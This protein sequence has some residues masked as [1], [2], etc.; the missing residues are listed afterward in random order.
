MASLYLNQ[1]TTK[2]K[3]IIAF[4]AMS[5]FF[6]GVASAQVE[7][8][9]T[10]PEKKTECTKSKE[11]CSKSAATQ[12]AEKKECT[13]AKAEGKS[14]CCSKSAAADAKKGKKKGKECCSKDA[15]TKGEH[16]EGC[17]EGEKKDCCKKA[18]EK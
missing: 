17:K 13:G 12:G 15:A 10:T 4:A 9:T 18:G 8:T 3:K 7:N 2:M 5:I 11:C 14:E 6:V 1:I 16:K